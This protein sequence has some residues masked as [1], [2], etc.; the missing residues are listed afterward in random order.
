[1]P[2]DLHGNPSAVRIFRPVSRHLQRTY[3]DED[4]QLKGFDSCQIANDVANRHQGEQDEET[5]Q[6]NASNS[7]QDVAKEFAGDQIVPVSLVGTEDSE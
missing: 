4:P 7:W 1:M 5:H 3:D 2:A 6:I